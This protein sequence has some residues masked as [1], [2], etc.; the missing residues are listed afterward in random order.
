MK[1]RYAIMPLNHN[2][3]LTDIQTQ[4]K[5]PD[6]IFQCKVQMQIQTSDVIIQI[7]YL[8]IEIV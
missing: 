2:N 5:N 1:I 3:P 6:N 7:T 4:R 8:D